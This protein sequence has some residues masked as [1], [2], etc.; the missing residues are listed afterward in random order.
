MNFY[1]TYSGKS[2]GCMCGCRGNY[3]YTAYGARA[4]NPGYDVSDKVSER[5]VN[6]IVNKLLR[7]PNTVN[8]DGMLYLDQNGR[9]LVAWFEH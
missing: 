3:N 8:E 2:G 9:S 4:H 7:N 5:G 1:K 6:I